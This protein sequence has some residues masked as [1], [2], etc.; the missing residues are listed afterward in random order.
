MYHKMSAACAACSLT[1]CAAL[2][3]QQGTSQEC[4]QNMKVLMTSQSLSV[5]YAAKPPSPTAPSSLSSF[6]GWGLTGSAL[7]AVPPPFSACCFFASTPSAEPSASGGS[8]F[9]LAL[10]TVKGSF[11][12]GL[13]GRAVDGGSDCCADMSALSSACDMQRRQALVECFTRS[14]AGHLQGCIT[15]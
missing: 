15:T 5:P 9:R 3:T 11:L 13:A 12:A 10:T 4:F 14:A 6:V 2:C 1:Q 8:A 7:G